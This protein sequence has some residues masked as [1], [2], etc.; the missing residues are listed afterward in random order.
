VNLKKSELLIFLLVNINHW[1]KF[2]KKL[3]AG[4]A[5]QFVNVNAENVKRWAKRWQNARKPNIASDKYGPYTQ[6]I[7]LQGISNETEVKSV[8]AKTFNPIVV[9]RDT[10]CL[11]NLK[12]NW[13][14]SMLKRKKL[15]RSIVTEPAPTLL[16]EDDV[17]KSLALKHNVDIVLTSDTLEAL[18]RHPEATDTRWT[19]PLSCVD[20]GT[21]SCQNLI[22][23]MEDPL[24]GISTPRECLSIGIKE[25][26]ISHAVD[27]IADSS[28]IQGKKTYT[29][30]TIPYPTGE[31]R[32]LVRSCNY[33]LDENGKPLIMFSQLEYFSEQCG[34]EEFT[35]H[36]HVVWLLHKILQDDCTI[37][38][39]RVDTISGEVLELEEKTVADA[40]TTN[41]ISVSERYLD[42]LGAF[43]K[44][45]GAN[46][47]A[48]SL[49]YRMST[50]LSATLLIEK[51]TEA[52]HIICLPG[53]SN[54]ISPQTTATVHK[55]QLEGSNISI[56]VDKEL[57]ENAA[58]VLLN[59]STLQSCF[60]R[61]QWKS[62]RLP[63]TFALKD[64]S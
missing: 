17:A 26:L 25:A 61:W 14:E 36:D 20:V 1:V 33:L 45:D 49:F 54:I 30:L 5:S 19:I 40:L 64:K 18:L 35:T 59:K 58:S 57:N 28:N 9:H 38:V 10:D 62:D 48:T 24:P 23:F 11:P 3:V 2:K 63:Y 31:Q 42:S 41:E 29:L 6:A 39:G 53:R 60:R 21:K 12:S 55:A 44:Q 51:K 4:P 32:V 7:S 37:V 13:R 22:M 16:C 43:E 8:G 50:V 27:T 46:D 52:R 15:R 56:D 34:I 47:N